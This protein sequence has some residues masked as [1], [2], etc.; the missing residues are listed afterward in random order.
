[1]L[2]FLACLSDLIFTFKYTGRCLR[3][4]FTDINSCG[5]IRNSRSHRLPVSVSFLLLQTYAPAEQCWYSVIYI[6]SKFLHVA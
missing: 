3:K 4:E 2:I 1:M 6:A 5:G